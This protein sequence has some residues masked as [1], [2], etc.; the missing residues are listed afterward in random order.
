VLERRETRSDY[1]RFRPP[2]IF[3]EDDCVAFGYLDLYGI[4]RDIWCRRK[5][6]KLGRWMVL[7]KGTDVL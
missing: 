2:R 5:H 4:I 3:S 1:P 7:I 6:Y